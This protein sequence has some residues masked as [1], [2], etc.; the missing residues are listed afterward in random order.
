MGR[1]VHVTRPPP[2]CVPYSTLACGSGGH[3]IIIPHSVLLSSDDDGGG[4]AVVFVGVFKPYLCP[5]ELPD[6]LHQP[7]RT[8]ISGGGETTTIFQR[9]QPRRLA[10]TSPAPSVVS[11]CAGYKVRLLVGLPSPRQRATFFESSQKAFPF[12]LVLELLRPSHN[13]RIA[14]GPDSKPSSNSPAF[15]LLRVSPRLLQPYHHHNHQRHIQY[16]RVTTAHRGSA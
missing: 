15:L 6:Q 16:P 2:A 14:P 11:S 13:S 5:R 1:H 8:L 12:S 4:L 7:A 10:Q 3:Q 9:N